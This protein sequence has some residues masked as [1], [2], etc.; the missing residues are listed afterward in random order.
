MNETVTI[1]PLQRDDYPQL[2]DLVR[3]T[4]Y[5]EFDECTGLI[6]AEAD[7]ENCLARTTNA[8]AAVKD[9][10]PVALILGRIDAHDTRGTW[11][12]HKR[13]YLN[14]LRRL[15]TAPEGIKA[16]H[17]IV[18]ILAIDH[19]LT[20]RARKSGHDYGAEV[21]LFVLD[22]EARGLGLGK[23]MF[24]R[25][26]AD[27]R[28]AGLSKYFLYTDTTCNVGFYEHTGLKQIESITLPASRVHQESMSFYLYEGTIDSQQTLVG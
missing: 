23:R 9:G 8:Y 11:N 22:P 10:K 28:T 20:H 2:I 26:I 1:R 18:G 6:A 17:E 16:I 5:A 27:F 14:G 19:Q 12:R 21:V 3:R 13:N 7:W 15:L 25:M 24:R 4:W